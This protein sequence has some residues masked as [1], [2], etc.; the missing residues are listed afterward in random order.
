MIYYKLVKVI[1][2]GMSL[3]KIIINI[4]MRYYNLPNLIITNQ[5]LFFTSKF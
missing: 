4:V 2:N 5:R 3:A 1:I